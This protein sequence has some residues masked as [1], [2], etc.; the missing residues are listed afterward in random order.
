M[1][2][3]MMIRIWTAQRS[4]QTRPWFHGSVPSEDNDQEDYLRG[5][6]EKDD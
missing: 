5:D 1:Q 3:K 2:E 4:T 6:D